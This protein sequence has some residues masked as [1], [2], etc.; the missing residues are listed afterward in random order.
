[1]KKTGN[2]IT[3][4]NDLIGKCFHSID[5][6]SGYIGWQGQIIGNPEPQWYLI[7]LYS[8]IAGDPTVCKLVNI[9][10]ISNWYF[11]QDEEAMKHSWE[12]GSAKNHNIMKKNG[13][14]PSA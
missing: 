10:E 5:P 14:D 3:E 12:Y 8:W 1:M 6:K 4:R 9:S 11:Y 2:T 7:Q 13:E